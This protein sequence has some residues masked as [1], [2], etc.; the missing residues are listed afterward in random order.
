MGKL[1]DLQHNLERL[2]EVLERVKEGSLTAKDDL[3]GTLNILL[4]PNKGFDLI[5][6]AFNENGLQQVELPG[7]LEKEVEKERDGHSFVLSIR[8]ANLE[9]EHL[10]PLDSFLEQE[11]VYHDGSEWTTKKEMTWM[12]I[13]KKSRNKFGSH[14]DDQPPK[15]LTTLRYYPAAN[16]DVMTLLLWSL[17]ETLLDSLTRHLIANGIDIDPYERSTSLSGIEF[18]KSEFIKLGGTQY[19]AGALI[20][21]N[22]ET[23]TKRTI[24]G[25]ILSNKPFILG[26]NARMQV[27]LIIGSLDQSL[28]ELESVFYQ[29]T[30]ALGMNRAQRRAAK[31]NRNNS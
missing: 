12:D 3:A 31:R 24:L 2:Q 9:N 14:V 17:G 16:A 10:I 6:K 25:G 8:T 29:G 5:K 4:S 26:L 13:V 1:E 18:Q 7:F 27:E 11:C 22:E 20:L 15:W 30:A 21:V 19:S 23:G 28:E